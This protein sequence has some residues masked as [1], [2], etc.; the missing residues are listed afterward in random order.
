MQTRT[1]TVKVC[2]AELGQALADRPK[3]PAGAKITSNA[4]GDSWL[5]A[6]LAWGD[7]AARLFTDARQACQAQAAAP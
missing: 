6:V 4:D 3:V 2:P 1:V 7:Q 5:E